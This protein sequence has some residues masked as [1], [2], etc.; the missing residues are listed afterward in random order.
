MIFSVPSAN[1]MSLTIEFVG[2]RGKKDSLAFILRT[3]TKMT[4]LVKALGRK[5]EFNPQDPHGGRANFH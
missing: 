1:L 4:Q 5:P 3:H 2:S